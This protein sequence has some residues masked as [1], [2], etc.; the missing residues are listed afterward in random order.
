M[1]RLLSTAALV[2]AVCAAAVALSAASSQPAS[3]KRYKIVFDN[4]FGLVEGGDFRVAGV[5]AG[6]TTKFSV[7]KRRGEAPKAVVTA[8]IDQ[9]GFG[10]FRSD[11]SCDIKP[12][13]LIGEYYVDCQPGSS[14]QK[15][16]HGIVPVEHTTSTI[17]QDLVNDI[18]R[19]PYRERLRLIITELGTGLAGRPHDLAQVLRRAHPGLRETSKVL[20]VLG[21]QSRV[22]ERFISDADTVVAQL[23]HNKT[24]V[25]RWFV[26][27]G[28][29]AATSATRRAQ[30]QQSLRRLPSFLDELRPTMRRLGDL[31]DQQTP[32]LVE[33]RRA[34]PQ[35]DTF[36]TRL[37]PFAKAS[38]P[39]IRSLGAA[40]KVGRRAFITGRQEVKEL[41]ALAKGAPAFAKPL[42]QFLQT[43]DDRRRA[44]EDDAHAVNG[45]PPAPDPTAF[46]GSGGFTGLEDIWNYFYYQSLA[47]NGYDDIGHV[48]RAG[49]TTDACG[50]IET[51]YGDSPD[52]PQLYKECKQW[53]GPHQPAITAPDP[54]EGGAAARR[55]RRQQ[56][57]PAKR[58]GERRRAGQP[59]AGPL[60]GQ[61]DLSK[62]QVVLPPQVKQLLNDLVPKNAL[63]NPQQLQQKLPDGGL[64]GRQTNQ[65]LDFL[66]G[67]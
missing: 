47:I 19:R 15:L 61:R 62:P 22:I 58:R 28:D 36:L 38:T 5:T 50:P 6:K 7:L 27:A 57:R 8:E 32:L 31:A 46:H 4:A 9:P 56:G 34:A 33:L 54:T 23:E 35:L 42:R 29:A 67:P 43:L 51:K 63:P 53:L 21:D 40:S 44:F 59:Q 13:S 48:L 60:P 18:L 17:P 64:D 3:G 52:D 37:G 49:V 12:Q 39:A 41:R 14:P 24:D 45:A 55:L 1:R 30:I 11:A 10:D 66:L 26:K 65:L 2:L 25:A 16:K 20:R